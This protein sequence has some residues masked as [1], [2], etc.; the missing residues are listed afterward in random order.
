[1]MLSSIKRMFGFNPEN[2]AYNLQIV[3]DNFVDTIAQSIQKGKTLNQS[4][5]QFNKI[6]YNEDGYIQGRNDYAGFEVTAT[7]YPANNNSHEVIVTVSNDKFVE[8]SGNV[9]RSI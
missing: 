6:G 9:I 5:W 7:V 8:M 3:A 2:Q 4:L 1:M